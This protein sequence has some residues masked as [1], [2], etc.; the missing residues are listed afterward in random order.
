MYLLTPDSSIENRF[1]AL[2]QIGDI[3]WG[4]AVSQDRPQSELPL[5]YLENARALQALTSSGPPHLKFL[6]L[7]V[8]KA[9][10][11]DRL[12]IDNWGLAIL[13][14]QHRGP[15]GNPFMALKADADYAVSTRRVIAK[16]NQCLRLAR[17]ASNFRGR[18][19]LPRALTE[20][21]KLIASFVGRIGRLEFTQIGGTASQFHVSVLQICKLMAW[22]AE[23]SGDQEALALATVAA[24]L[25]VSSQDRCL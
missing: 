11:L 8:R 19:I 3:D 25:P 1:W 17:Y 4:G 22:I 5:L 21:F 16:Y 9:A 2:E 7:I 23:E 14:Y 13:L 20:S 18:W 6:A 24:L 10:E 15:A 12:V